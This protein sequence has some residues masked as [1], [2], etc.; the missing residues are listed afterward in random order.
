MTERDIYSKVSS[1]RP[2]P[3][4]IISMYIDV[5]FAIDS[6][7]LLDATAPHTCNLPIWKRTPTLRALNMTTAIYVEDLNL[8][9]VSTKLLM[10][11]KAISIRVTVPL[12]HNTDNTMLKAEDPFPEDDDAAWTVEIAK[13]MG[14]IN[15]AM[16]GFL[17]G[18]Q[19]A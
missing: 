6:Q 2:L 1:T 13:K 16:V 12:H 4:T 7:D 15:G 5:P 10:E 19:L 17:F 9:Q 8:T 11:A 3:L 14:T 18:A